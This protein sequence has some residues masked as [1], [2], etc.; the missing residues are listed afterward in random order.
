MSHRLALSY[1][2]IDVPELPNISAG[3]DGINFAKRDAGLTG[4]A[5][6]KLFTFS[7]WIKLTTGND[8]RILASS[9]T[10][11]G[12]ANVRFTIAGGGTDFQVI[13]LNS[14][15]SGILD[16][17]SSSLP[18][19]RWVNIL[20]SCDMAD[21]AKRHIYVD[22]VSDLDSIA[23]YTNDTIDFTKADWAVGA[24]P[25][26]ARL[27][28]GGLANLWFQPGLYTDFSVEA[29][30]RLFVLEGGFPADLGDDGS[31][32]TGTSPLVYLSGPIDDWHT[33]KGTGGGFTITGATEFDEVM[34]TFRFSSSVNYL[35]NDVDAIPSIVS[36]DLSPAI[37]SLG[38]NLG[39]RATLTANFR[40]HKHIFNY[41]DFDSGTFWGKFR[42]RYGLKLQGRTL[43]LLYGFL[44][45]AISGMETRT[46][47]I[48][49][50]DGPSSRGEFKIVAKDLFKFADG[51]RSQAPI[52]SG[53]FLSSDITA[54][55]VG[56]TL[57]PTGI[58]DTDY[59]GAGYVAIGG[60]EI[61][62][63][64]RTGVD[65]FTVL[66]L[67]MQLGDSP[68]GFLDS[69]ASGHVFLPNGNVTVT[70]GVS[71]AEFKFGAGSAAFDGNNDY[72]ELSGTSS[73]FAYGTGDFT[74][75][76][77]VKLAALGTIRT[78]Y[79]G[80]NTLTTDQSPEIRI[81]AADQITYVANN[82]IRITSTTTITTSAFTHVA[83]VRSGGFTKLYVAGVN[84]GAT[85]TDANNYVTFTNRPRIG[86][87]F[88]GGDDFFG[89]IG[90]FR[91]SN[92]ARWIANFT[93]P[94][95]AYSTAGSGDA[96]TLV[97][98]QYNTEAQA[99]NAQSRVQVCLEFLAQDVA[100]IINDLM[101]DFADID[102]DLIPLSTWLA[103]TGEFINTV[104]SAL[105]TEPTAVNKLISE[106]VEQAG[107]V[108]WWDDLANTF[109]LQVLR[110]ISTASAT[111]N[112]D[113]YMKDTLKVTE[114]PSKRLSQVYVYFDKINPLINDDQ[115]NNYRST[116][117]DRDLV[118]EAEYGA[119]AVKKIFSRW[120][121][122]GG[123]SVADA[124]IS[125]LLS[126]FRD[127]PRRLNFELFRDESGNTP[128]LGGG[129]QIE[130]WPFQDM[131][132]AAVAVPVQL[133]S[134]GALPEKFEIEAEEMLFI[135]T[136][137]SPDNHVIIFDASIN[138]VNL[139]T[140]HDSIYSTPVSGDTV[141]CTVA[142]GVIIGSTSVTVAAFEVGDWPAGVTINLIVIGRIQGKG[143]NGGAGGVALFASS[144][145]GAAGQAGGTAL[146]SRESITLSGTGGVWGG[147]GG[148]GGDGGFHTGSAGFG[149]YGGGG[150]AGTNTG[151]GGTGGFGSTAS[152]G[153]GTAG[154]S[155]A[156][157]TESRD[158][159]GPGL[160]GQSGNSTA[161]AGGGA[162]GAAGAAI[163]G[164]GTVSGTVS[165]VRGAVS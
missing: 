161:T 30:R 46:F 74:I 80:K 34:K 37:L 59:V 147:G 1:V 25:D 138:N 44:G 125:I 10:L 70:T 42:A 135:V 81:N 12:G 159:G 137:T 115:I 150:G 38:E 71:P 14:A 36:I 35:P 136:A 93:P 75:D 76:F 108:V 117:F 160:A 84:E 131:A 72:L 130:G 15:G 132:G 32:P 92:V 61:V 17:S 85:Y 18:Y 90:E 3:F 33:N 99:H 151:S 123:R 48:E 78:I 107:L 116:A 20:C 119:V 127:P 121:P 4:A 16:I 79:D 88:A 103:E 47:T 63:Y 43:R 155:E 11:G 65:E 118:A 91:I 129:Y 56:L 6:S 120:I 152:G 158:G 67:H 62:R 96:M 154:T 87:N 52:L 39:Q 2:E 98:A 156:G 54:A 122:T 109:R 157:G 164:A 146:R 128:I 60:S 145:G 7:C 68:A 83:L 89:W 165:D 112:G 27:L 140:T 77:W 111:Y 95:A 148:A 162:A 141:T 133:T 22:D 73:D 29:N 163:D 23:T 114:Q 113:I 110:A 45:Q 53:G 21:T 40:D 9:S 26:G 28:N 8:G 105:I 64:N 49:S 142:A 41:E 58:G 106:L 31:T 100:Q 55:D 143:G 94:T 51:E 104:Y 82:A 139:R 144:S 149:G 124:V 5:D 50:T 57:S 97:R 86:S 66:L 69:S 19:E 24:A 102:Q 153:N 126:R 13:G 101:V 134:V